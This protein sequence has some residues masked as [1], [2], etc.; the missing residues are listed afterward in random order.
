MPYFMFTLTSARGSESGDITS[1][2]TLQ[3]QWTGDTG[4]LKQ[5]HQHWEHSGHNRGSDITC[6]HPL[7]MWWVCYCLCLLCGD[8]VSLVGSELITEY[9][10]NHT[11]IRLIKCNLLG[12]S[13]TLAKAPPSATARVGAKSLPFWEQRIGESWRRMQRDK[14]WQWETISIVLCT[15]ERPPYDEEEDP[16]DVTGTLRKRGDVN[17]P[18][19][20]CHCITN[21]TCHGNASHH[22]PLCVTIALCRHLYDDESVTKHKTDSCYVICKVKMGP[23]LN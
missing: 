9:T 13:M 4:M 19:D 5:T 23:G 11:F 22:I 17:I 7:T 16:G 21:I 2:V 10:H 6:S 15:E 14:L 20:K 12:D 8:I 1:M 18:H 3:S